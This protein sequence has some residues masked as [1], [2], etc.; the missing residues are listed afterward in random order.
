MRGTASDSAVGCTRCLDSNIIQQSLVCWPAHC[1]LTCQAVTEQ[2]VVWSVRGHSVD[3]W[4]TVGMTTQATTTT[5]TTTPRRRCLKTHFATG[6]VAS[7]ACVCVGAE[8][9]GRYQ[10]ERMTMYMRCACWKT[11]QCLRIR[12]KVIVQGRAIA[13]LDIDKGG[14]QTR[15]C[16]LYVC[17]LQTMI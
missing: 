16:E 15:R 13:F 9:T 6:L 12:K 17:V 5:V 4:T 14:H 10:Y 7:R 2:L 1:F 8:R 3:M 11:N